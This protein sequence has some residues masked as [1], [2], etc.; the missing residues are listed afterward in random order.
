MT[1]PPTAPGGACATWP[2]VQEC[3]PDCWTADPAGWTPLQ[4]WAVMAA[5]AILRRL[6][7][8]VFNTCPITIRPCRRNCPPERY[9]YL[10]DP[11]GLPWQP[12]MLDGKVYNLTCGVCRDTCGC[13]AISEV[14]L[15]PPA[16]SIM[17]VKV[18][19]KV[20]PYTAYRVD[21]WRRLVRL[22]GGSWPECQK[23]DRPD[24][25]PDTWS[26]TYWTGTPPDPG[27]WFALTDLAVEF[28]KACQGKECALG[29]NVRQVARQGI[30]YDVDT[31]YE[32]IREGRTGLK[33]VDLWIYS[34]N[35]H[36]LRRRMSVYSPDIVHGRRTTWPTT[37]ALPPEPVDPGQL[38]T[39][40][41]FTTPQDV[42][43]IP[44][45]LSFQPAG[46]Q[47]TDMSGREVRGEVTYPDLAT[48]QITFA[49]PTAGRVRLS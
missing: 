19:G 17:Q 30:T 37:T 39:T 21:D 36:G 22:D 43:V 10:G 15:D 4:R 1:V 12:A 49:Q 45:G 6:T 40:W 26:V 18:D 44:H 2:L 14:I 7:A 29:V 16:Y 27:A 33:R 48:I 28:W 38:G 9:R 13:S 42:W 31:V 25:E 24:T 8:G 34:V 41:V 32:S 35:P 23:I 5:A 11:L 46:V 20:L 3:L 47:I